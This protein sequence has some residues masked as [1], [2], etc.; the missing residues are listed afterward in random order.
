MYKPT[1]EY[2]IKTKD[3]QFLFKQMFATN[4]NN[5]LGYNLTDLQMLLSANNWQALNIY[6]ER[7]N[8]AHPHD[9]ALLHLAHE[10]NF[11]GIEVPLNFPWITKIFYNKGVSVF[12]KFNKYF[13]KQG[14]PFNNWIAE[15]L[16]HH[17]V[18][19]DLLQEYA[20]T[21]KNKRYVPQPEG[22][23]L[24]YQVLEYHNRNKE[25]YMQVFLLDLLQ[26]CCD[27]IDK[28]DSALVRQEVVRFAKNHPS[29]SNKAH[30][31]YEALVSS[32]NK[33]DFCAYLE[34]NRFLEDFFNINAPGIKLTNSNGVHD[35]LFNVANM[36]RETATPMNKLS[37]GLNVLASVLKEEF[38]DNI[39]WRYTRKIGQLSLYLPEENLNYVTNY[40]NEILNFIQT[41]TLFLSDAKSIYQKHKLE[42]QL[43]EGLKIKKINK[44]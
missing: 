21:L 1:Y 25:K 31:R 30:D 12:R 4:G 33:E 40:I 39:E 35:Y 32:L 43:P 20:S 27:N 37:I 38:G 13:E 3:L 6:P 16:L 8:M 19:Y 14:F 29:I 34:K 15:N 18:R 11:E 41:D 17:N 36:S 23:L 9:L 28:L 7:K 2:T 26:V 24:A 42:E 22:F 44:I 10:K 5:D